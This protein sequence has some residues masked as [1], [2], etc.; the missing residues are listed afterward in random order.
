MENDTEESV[1]K[2]I[3]YAKK[4]NTLVAQ[5]PISTPYPG[6][7]FFEKMRNEGKITSF[8][9]EDYDE[10]TPVFKHK[11]LSHEQLLA[12]K[13]KAFVSY[14]FRLS[15]FVKYLPTFLKIFL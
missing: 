7:A 10:Y 4:L 15:Y 6:T 3:D 12:L 8:N 5:F 9:W 13:E 1:N 14:Y 11:F 2:T